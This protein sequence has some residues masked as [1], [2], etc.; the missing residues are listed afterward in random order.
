MSFINKIFKIK[1]NNSTISKEILGGIITFFSICY[2]LFLNPEIIAN[3]EVN[4]ASLYSGT[5]ICAKAQITVP[6]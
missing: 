3:D 2:V 5:V 1:E 6:L 4:K